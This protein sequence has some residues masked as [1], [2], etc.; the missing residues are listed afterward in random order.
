VLRDGDHVVLN[1]VPVVLSSIW[2]GFVSTAA[3]IPAQMTG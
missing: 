3:T 1:L 2:A